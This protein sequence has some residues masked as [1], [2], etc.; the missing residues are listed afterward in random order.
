MID[1][2][3]LLLMSI[4]VYVLV[5]VFTITYVYLCKKGN[6]FDP[7]MQF[8]FFFTLFTLPLP[9][10]AL[11]D[12]T[13]EGDITPHLPS[14]IPYMPVAVFMAS[15]GLIFFLVVYYSSWP[16]K[17]ASLLPIPATGTPSGATFSFWFLACFS[18]FLVYKLA[19]EAGGIIPFLLLGYKSSE[20][21][22][23][24]GYLAIGFPW[25]FVATMF[26]LYKY[27]I[28]KKKLSLCYFVVA[29]LSIC[30]GQLLMG[31]RSMIMYMGITVV[32]FVHNAIHPV[33]KKILISIGVAS[34]LA[35]NIVGFL[36][37]SSY[38][39]LED[40]VHRSTESFS[41]TTKSGDGGFFYTLTTGEFIVP[42]ETFPQMIKSVGD[43]IT[44]RFGESFVSATAFFVPTVLFPDRPL[45]LTTWYMRTFYDPTTALNEGR[46]FYFLAEG[47]LNFGPAGV[48]LVM[49]IW[50]LVL[51]TFK[52]YIDKSKGEPG[53]V[54]IYS[55]SIAFIFRGIAGDF[56]VMLVGLPEQSLSAAF[57]GILIASRFH[58]RRFV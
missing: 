58:K 22:F 51:G 30:I 23:G 40:F 26:F 15:I 36:R 55:L 3:T 49:I 52:E 37:G 7:I 4:C 45:P 39:S 48:F 32:L 12:K 5:L 54:L 35:L 25:F 24:K 10:R 44:P 21:T 8:V 57:L 53:A 28:D 18:I 27:S 2:N 46:A 9:L 38:D 47:Y 13:I 50:G 20:K 31:S 29:F 14:L 33:S 16:R 17:I 1:Y 19:Q 56:S 11:V 6:I 41:N 42:F 43:D 34:F